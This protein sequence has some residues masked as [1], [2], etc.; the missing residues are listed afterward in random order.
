MYL[1]LFLR[2]KKRFLLNILLLLSVTGFFCMS[3][4][5]YQNSVDNLQK[6]D[7]TYRTIAIMELHGSVNSSGELLEVPNGR[8]QQ[9]AVTGY[10]Y[11]SVL[12]ATGVLGHDLRSKYGIVIDGTI[13]MGAD[14]TN[15][16][17]DYD[18]IRFRLAQDE[19]VT[20]PVIWDYDDYDRKN[21]Q[22]F[23]LEVLESAAGCFDYNNGKS[24]RMRDI[25]MDNL[26]QSYGDDIQRLNRSEENGSI[27]L[28]PGVEYVAINQLGMGWEK[29][30]PLDKVYHNAG[31]IDLSLSTR[32]DYFADDFSVHYSEDGTETIATHWYGGWE[33]RGGMPC[34][35]MRWEDVQADP[36]IFSAY[37]GLW[38]AAKYNVSTFFATL[39][40]DITGVPLYHVG[41]AYLRSGR[42][43]SK[44]E[45]QTGAKVC[46]VSGRLA[47]MQGWRVGDRLDLRFFRFG[48]FPNMSTELVNQ[49]PVYH[50]NTKGFF[51]E[52]QYE[53][54]GIFDTRDQGASSGIA[55]STMNQPWNTVYL[56]TNS[57]QNTLPTEELPVHGALLTIWLENGSIPDFLKD[58]EAM[59]LLDEDPTRYNPRFIFYDQGY[60]TIQPSLQNLYGTA[61]L[62]LGLSSLLL[63]ITATL[64]A[65]FFSQHHRHNI[66]ILR[67]LGGVRS[68]ALLAMVLCALFITLLGGA[69]G[70]AIGH[71]LA[72]QTGT[73]I[74][75]GSLAESQQTAG[76]CSYVMATEDS[77]AQQLSVKAS[78]RISALSTCGA[79]LFPLLT[80]LFTLS[81]LNCEPRAL[82]PRA[83]H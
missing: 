42:M 59:G 8:M 75:E 62:L 19:P 2:G 60:S 18:I 55:E 66:G 27:T 30:R 21:E 25:L 50:K 23:F 71:T 79:L 58:I 73:Y 80:M 52:G 26:Q 9:V 35:I 82:L 5:L 17:T 77:V 56:P 12:D 1:T 81:Y 47:N 64:L 7:D 4:N 6:A 37:T 76:F 57:V 70:A 51:D 69:A 31:K 61:R 11:S 68:R 40:G 63:L 24:V 15:P 44:E 43:I 41:G 72:E 38:D 45:Y 14:G 34:P 22:E 28:Y 74:L 78:P 48:A 53:I 16:L 29:D 33:T 65:W 36:E 3:I 49:Q 54:V 20:I 32:L 67:M 10:D 39:T 83:K 13:A 46:M